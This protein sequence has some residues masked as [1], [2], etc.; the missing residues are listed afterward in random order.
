LAQETLGGLGITLSASSENYD[1]KLADNPQAK[2][3]SWQKL[4]TFLSQDQTDTHEYIKNVYD[5]SEY[6]RDVHNNAESAGIR[7]AVIS[8]RFK[9]EIEGHALNAFLTTDCGLVYVDCTERDTIARIVAGKTYRA[10]ELSIVSKTNIRDDSW[11]NALWVY[12]YIP[13]Y[14]GSGEVITSSIVIYW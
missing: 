8:I 4:M 2:N 9:D 1:A 5:C 14:K 10:T 13:S 11:W 7:A 12:Y 3:P 6:S